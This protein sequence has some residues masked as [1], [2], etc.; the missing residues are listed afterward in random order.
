ME[1]T[2]TVVYVP[3]DIVQSFSRATRLQDTVQMDVPLDGN[4]RIPYVPQVNYLRMIN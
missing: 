3:V 2:V 1:P 4:G